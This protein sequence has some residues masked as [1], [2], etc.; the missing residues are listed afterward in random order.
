MSNLPLLFAEHQLLILFCECGIF[1]LILFEN[2]VMV[3][4]FASFHFSCASAAFAPDCCAFFFQVLCEQP[5][6]LEQLVTVTLKGRRIAFFEMIVCLLKSKGLTAVL[7]FEADLIERVYNNSVN[8]FR[9]ELGGPACR[10]VIAF[11]Q[12]LFYASI[13]F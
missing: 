7:A 5:I 4:K 12:P 11:H 8:F 13:A 9:V 2:T 10:T 6:V 3:L 1:Y